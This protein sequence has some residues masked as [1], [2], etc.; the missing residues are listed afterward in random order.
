MAKL[1]WA[2]GNA[3]VHDVGLDRGVVYVNGVAEA[4]AGLVSVEQNSEGGDTKGLYYLGQK[5]ANVVGY[6]EYAAT[7]AAV[8]T[9]ALFKSVMGYQSIA[10]GLFAGQQRRSSFNLTYR[11]MISVGG[12]LTSDYKIHLVYNA[13][14]TAS[15]GSLYTLSDEPADPTLEWDIT[16]LPPQAE[17]HVPTAYF[18][19]DTRYALPAHVQMLEN[20][21]Y[22]TETTNP[23][24]PTVEALRSI[25]F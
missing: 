20:V 5:Y 23:S 9:P 19:V 3:A 25:V 10:R 17:G 13:T 1:V 16:T 2:D 6:E 22:G 4:W 12:R 14:T 7:I 8:T 15:N 11:S 24:M 21:L 18:I